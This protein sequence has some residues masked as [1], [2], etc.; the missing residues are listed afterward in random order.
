MVNEFTPAQLKAHSRRLSAEAKAEGVRLGLRLL[1][2]GAGKYPLKHGG[3]PLPDPMPF[4][5]DAFCKAVELAFVEGAEWC[6]R[7]LLET[8]EVTDGN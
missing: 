5:Q 2:V 3:R 8:L 6:T 4:T 7:A 1:A